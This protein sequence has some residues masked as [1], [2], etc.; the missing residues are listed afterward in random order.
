MLSPTPVK[1]KISAKFK[2]NAKTGQP[3][4]GMTKDE[5]ITCIGYPPAHATESTNQSI[6]T[7]WW[8]RFNTKELI[9]KGNILNRIRD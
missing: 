5:V 8:S 6:W 2:T 7:Y 4:I 9:F 1:P 3:S